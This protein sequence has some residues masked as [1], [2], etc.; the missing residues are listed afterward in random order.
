METFME[1]INSN[2]LQVD[3][4]G[5]HH[6][7]STDVEAFQERMMT[8][9]ETYGR[10]PLLITE[11]GVADWQAQSVATNRFKPEQVLSFMET[12]LPWMEEQD[13]II[14]YNWFSFSINDPRGTSSALHDNDGNLTTLGSFYGSFQGASFGYSTTTEG[15]LGKCVR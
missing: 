1:R 9:Y 5:V 14:G 6:Y 8:I 7:G 4:I 13:W 3:V 12:I 15:Q 2:G 11:L 10:R